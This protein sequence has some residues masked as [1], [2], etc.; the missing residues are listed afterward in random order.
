MTDD[1]PAGTGDFPEGPDSSAVKP[2]EKMGLSFYAALGL[3]GILVL[4]VVVINYP[5]A[6]AD[7]G[8]VM[9]ETNWTLQ[10]LADST[11]ILVPA[12]SGTEVTALFDRE[13]RVSGNAG[14]NRY[15]ATYQTR[16]YRINITGAG[17]TKMFC[18]GPGIMEQESAFLGYLSRADSFR[19]SESFLK[20][21][22]ASGKTVLVFTP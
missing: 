6:R 5:T 8:R 14:C 9:T 19:I 16:D 4:M 21:F 17:S 7:A 18:Q 2:P 1:S 11:G 22:D 13:G 15:F 10:S 20:I 3:I 12:Q